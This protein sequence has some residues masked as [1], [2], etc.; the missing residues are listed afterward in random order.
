MP[1]DAR[2]Y[3]P[4]EA[5][6]LSEIAVKAVNNAIDKHI[7]DAV[8]SPA[9]KSGRAGLGAKSRGKR[10]L[11]RDDVVLLR[12]WRS[13]GGALPPERRAQLLSAIKANRDL[14]TF[15]VD[16]VLIVDVGAARRE[17][18]E[19]DRMLAAANEAIISNPDVLG[20][21]PVFRGTR[22]SVYALAAMLEG[23]ADEDDLLANYP[24]MNRHMLDMARIWVA[25]NPRVGRPKTMADYGFVLKSTS[26]R[27]MPPERAAARQNVS[28]KRH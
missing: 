17:V 2:L 5:G 25:G 18:D 21:E 26:R 13:I 23:D 12:V 15:K 9:R 1:S 10:L 7:V 11:T 8:S 4:A 16:E 3:T 19:R 24:K 22:M 20:G 14:A 28:R 6:A 27:P